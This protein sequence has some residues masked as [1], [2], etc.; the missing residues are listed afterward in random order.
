[1]QQL[2]A[3]AEARKLNEWRDGYENLRTLTLHNY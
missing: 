1:M 2:N 3:L